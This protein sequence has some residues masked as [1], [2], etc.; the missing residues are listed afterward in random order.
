MNDTRRPLERFH[1]TSK[2]VTIPAGG[3]EVV[4]VEGT[5]VRCTEAT[6]PFKLGL[7]SKP[8]F[9]FAL[10]RAIDLFP[11]GDYFTHVTLENDGSDAVTVELELG[12]GLIY[13]DRLNVVDNRIVGGNVV[14]N[15]LIIR[16]P[17]I[18]VHSGP[19]LLKPQEKKMIVKANDYD[20]YHLVHRASDLA[21]GPIIVGGAD[22]GWTDLTGAYSHNGLAL[23]PTASYGPLRIE[24]SADLYAM[25]ITTGTADCHVGV[26]TFRTRA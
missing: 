21:G 16:Q 18:V 14:L 22:V 17:E 11:L 23:H 15:G 3:R 6:G 8:A 25:N 10:G 2:T 4:N 1:I 5:F 13:D 24:A 12:Y 20:V 19:I 26:I 7:E 9:N